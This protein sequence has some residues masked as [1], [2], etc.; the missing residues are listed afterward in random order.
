MTD[1]SSV[2]RSFSEFAI[3][4]TD[5]LIEVECIQNSIKRHKSTGEAGTLRIVQPCGIIVDGF[6]F[7]L[8]TPCHLICIAG[9]KIKS[10]GPSP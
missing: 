1:M 2:P 3:A 10:H 9:R 6:Y 8:S 5:G 4:S 7:L